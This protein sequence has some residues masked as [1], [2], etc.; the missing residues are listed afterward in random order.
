MAKAKKQSAP[1][2][3][4]TKAVHGATLDRQ[5]RKLREHGYVSCAEAASLLCKD[6]GTV[7]RWF[8]EETVEGIA[9]GRRKYIKLSS[10]I[11]HVGEDVAEIFGLN[12]LQRAI[13][14]EK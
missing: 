4:P 5:S 14:N 6:L 3:D 1:L 7:Y 12:E 2:L 11:E 9:V 10:L 8:D 13:S